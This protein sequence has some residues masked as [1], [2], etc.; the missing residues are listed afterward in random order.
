[1]KNLDNKRNLNCDILRIIAFVF[2]VSVHALGNPSL[3][4]D[5]VK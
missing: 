3:T 1:M 4:V 2:V 5:E